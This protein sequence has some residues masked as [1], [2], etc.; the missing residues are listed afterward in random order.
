MRLRLPQPS[1][2][3]VAAAQLIGLPQKAYAHRQ[4]LEAEVV[5]DPSRLDFFHFSPR[6]PF[7]VSLIIILA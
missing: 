6:I 2:E 3:A 4:L 1:N 5:P 7:S